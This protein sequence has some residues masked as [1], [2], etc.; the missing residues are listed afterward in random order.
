MVTGNYDLVGGFNPIEKYESQLGW[1]FP[2]YA[3]IEMFQTTDHQSVIYLRASS[4]EMIYSISEKC[5]CFNLIYVNLLEA[6]NQVNLL[7]N[8]L[9]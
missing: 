1:L 3:K 2:G 6:Q 7:M 4:S 5:G 9:F 8:Q